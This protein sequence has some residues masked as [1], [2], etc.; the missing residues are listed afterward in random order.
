MNGGIESE[1][2]I[3]ISQ[4]YRILSDPLERAYYDENGSAREPE[5]DDVQEFAENLLSELREEQPDDV[6]RWLYL[7]K[8]S[9]QAE[10]T[11]QIDHLSY[12]IEK[13]ENFLKRVIKSPERNFLKMLVDQRKQTIYA[14]MESLEGGMKIYGEAID[15]IKEEYEFAG[16]G[17]YERP[18]GMF[19]GMLEAMHSNNINR[20]MSDENNS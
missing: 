17:R 7:K 8:Q 3:E 9:N 10:I 1:E 16:I 18:S 20:L 12:E 6:T 14:Q 4:A 11:K 2:F 13:Y 15:W 19:S 5:Q